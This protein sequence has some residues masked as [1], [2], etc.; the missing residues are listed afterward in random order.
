[1]VLFLLILILS[2]NF[3]IGIFLQGYHQLINFKDF[4]ANLAMANSIFGFEWRVELKTVK[5][6]NLQ[7]NQSQGTTI[8]I[9]SI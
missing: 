5:N 8:E 9:V 4:G 1:M 7:L 2:F 3:L 6:G